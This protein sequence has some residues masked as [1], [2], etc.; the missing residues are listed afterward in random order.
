M[1][2]GALRLHRARRRDSARLAVATARDGGDRGIGEWLRCSKHAAQRLSD[3]GLG[4][5]EDPTPAVELDQPE[6]LSA[7]QQAVDAA[8]FDLAQLLELVLGP[9]RSGSPAYQHGGQEES[10]PMRAEWPVAESDLACAPSWFRPTH[11][12]F[13]IE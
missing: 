3:R 1:G 13:Y 5:Y 12:R 11:I 8:S 6:P 2:E 9:T 10:T 7:G 4:A